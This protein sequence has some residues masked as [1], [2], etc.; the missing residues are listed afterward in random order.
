MTDP[1]CKICDGEG[2]VHESDRCSSDGVREVVCECSMPDE[3]AGYDE[4]KDAEA[5]AYFDKKGDRD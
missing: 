4:M 2:T 5:E 1:D 3:D